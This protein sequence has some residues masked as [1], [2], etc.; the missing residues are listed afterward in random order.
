MAF[1][2]IFILTMEQ[3]SHKLL[4]NSHQ[5]ALKIIQL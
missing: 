1:V 4:T 2:D 5:L 3:L